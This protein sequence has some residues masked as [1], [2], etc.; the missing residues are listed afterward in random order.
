MR[1]IILVIATLIVYF[2]TGC[3][4]G[5]STGT[6]IPDAGLDETPAE[7]TISEME[8]SDIETPEDTQTT[9]AETQESPDN[10]DPTPTNPLEGIGAVQTLGSGFGFLEGPVY[11]S[12]DGSLYFS[13][14]PADTI[15]QLSADGSTTPFLENQPTNGLLFDSQNRLVIATQ[16]GRTLSRLEES[17]NVEVLVERFEGALL[18]SPNDV[19]LHSNGDLYFTDPPFGIAPEASEVG[20]AGVY[21]FANDGSL[22]QFW[23][24][25]IDTRPNGIALSP[26]QDLLYVSFFSS[27]EI[28]TWSIAPDGSVG[29]MAAFATTAGS[30]DGIVIDADGNLFVASSAGIEV[31]APDGTLWGVIEVPE[32]VS[33]AV[34][35]ALDDSS[36]RLLDLPKHTNR[37]GS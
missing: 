31:F 1:K 8:V 15:F 18:N 16:N 24:N 25:G 12:D 34:L 21:R 2:S 4:G 7:Q 22:S 32:R 13:D 30:A 27:G 23:C 9:E 26:N 19:A 28:F 10:I 5:G 20:C 33:I 29:E 11:R 17:G 36:Y 3:G 14:I 6:P 35:S 37:E